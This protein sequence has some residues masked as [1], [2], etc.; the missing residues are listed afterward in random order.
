MLPL[1][2]HSDVCLFLFWHAQAFPGMRA[3]ERAC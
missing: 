3:T 2:A 1:E